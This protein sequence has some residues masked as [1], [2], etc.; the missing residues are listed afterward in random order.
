PT[1]DG[2]LPTLDGEVALGGDTVPERRHFDQR[3]FQMG[4]NLDTLSPM[5]LLG[6][7]AEANV[8]DRIALG[9][10]AGVSF[11]GPEARAYVR[12]RPI[13]W[14]GEGQRL[15]NAFTLRS[16]YRVMRQVS[17]DAL[18]VFGGAESVGAEYVSRT[19][20]SWGLSAGF[21]HQLWSGWT[22]RYDFGF[23][24]VFSATPWQCKL[25]SEPAPCEGEPPSNDLLMT[26]FGVSHT[27]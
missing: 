5:A 3:S 26:S 1:F 27:L 18:D 2:A 16:E 7:F 24:R 11:G 21:E 9:V 17:P 13:V 4:A 15:L 25:G 22:I 20:Q 6:V 19:A 10:G 23:A 12:F 14:G 8:W